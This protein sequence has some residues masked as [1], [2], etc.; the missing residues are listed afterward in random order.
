MRFLVAAL[1]TV[2]TAPFAAPVWANDAPKLEDFRWIARP[3]VVFA[4]SEFDPAVA[5]QLQ[6]LEEQRA[7]LE[8][9]DVVILVDTDPSVASDLRTVLRPRGFEA[10]VIGK[11]GQVLL[12]KP[13]P[14][15]AREIIRQIDRTPLRRQE[16]QNQKADGG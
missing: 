5:E 4:E 12:R 15:T 7:D 10:V 14:L 9:R 11:E 16:I 3:V 13:R 6:Y 1:F 2:L 8:D